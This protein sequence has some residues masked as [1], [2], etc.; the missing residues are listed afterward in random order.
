MRFLK[1]IAASSA[2]ENTREFTNYFRNID[3]EL[4]QDVLEGFHSLDDW[5]VCF[6]NDCYRVSAV[7]KRKDALPKMVLFFIT[8]N[9][10]NY[11]VVNRV[12]EAKPIFA[13]KD[14]K[15]I[16]ALDPYWEKGGISLDHEQLISILSPY[17]SSI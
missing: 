13:S 6:T 4:L 1:V 15:A 17:K 2:P 9:K 8:F 3:K 14:P 12:K 16:K 7:C 11:I 5:G 10:K